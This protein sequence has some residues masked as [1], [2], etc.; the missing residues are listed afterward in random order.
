MGR[1]WM[2]FVSKNGGGV[3]DALPVYLLLL[4]LL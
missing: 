3:G 2:V 4:G 1:G